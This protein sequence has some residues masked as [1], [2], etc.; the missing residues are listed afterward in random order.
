MKGIAI[1]FAV[2]LLATGCAAVSM[3]PVSSTVPSDVVNFYSVTDIYFDDGMVW[4]HGDPVD[5]RVL[6]DVYSTVYKDEPHT[7]T[8]LFKFKREGNLFPNGIPAANIVKPGD[9][10]TVIKPTRS[11]LDK[12]SSN[13][14]VNFSIASAL[15]GN[16]NYAVTIQRKYQLEGIYFLK[17]QGLQPVASYCSA[18]DQYMYV[19]AI[20][21][22]SLGYVVTTETK[23]K[24]SALGIPGNDV[25]ASVATDNQDTKAGGLVI[26]LATL[27]DIC[28][29]G[30]SQKTDN[31]TNNEIANDLIK[32]RD[33]HIDDFKINK[34]LVK[35]SFLLQ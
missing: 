12:L 30:K 21:A 5:E 10:G 2:S 24:A 19:R 33:R 7:S 28:D 20:H 9:P 35:N 27:K 16:V 32:E 23:F 8:S 3:E 29:T 4:V 13:S 26:E 14:A 18:P 15:G 25:N 6:G 22:G 17:P 11:K 31:R 1:A 34:T